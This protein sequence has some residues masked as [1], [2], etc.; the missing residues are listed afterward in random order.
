MAVEKKHL[1]TLKKHKPQTVFIKGAPTLGKILCFGFRD[2]GLVVVA[3][4]LSTAELVAQRFCDAG[5]G[6]FNPS[7]CVGLRCDSLAWFRV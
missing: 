2:V 5:L 3:L 4:A 6:V 7:C 1:R